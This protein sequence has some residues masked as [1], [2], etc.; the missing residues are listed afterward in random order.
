MLDLW[1]DII[2]FTS[3]HFVYILCG[4][5]SSRVEQGSLISWV[6]DEDEG[7]QDA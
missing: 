7:E 5:R 3:N 2:W 6:N 1:L 4:I